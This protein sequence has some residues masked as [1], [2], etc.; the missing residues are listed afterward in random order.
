M[1]HSHQITALASWMSPQPILSAFGSQPA[2]QSQ[3]ELPQKVFVSCHSSAWQW[4][5]V[6]LACFLI[7]QS[8]YIWGTAQTL[9]S[10]W[11]G[12]PFRLLCS[13]PPWIW[14]PCLCVS[15]GFVFQFLNLARSSLLGTLER[16]CILLPMQMCTI[17]TH[18]VYTLSQTG[19]EKTGFFFSTNIVISC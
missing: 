6:P 16:V 19:R 13:H 10:T 2:H 7:L 12:W 1:P 11:A 14:Y 8:G 9:V 17:S 18:L 15:N 5:D 3:P 4:E